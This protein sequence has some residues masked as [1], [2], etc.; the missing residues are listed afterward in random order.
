[1]NYTL[2][3]ATDANDF[4]SIAE[5][6]KE[7]WHN[8]Y[9]DIIGAEQVDYMLDKFQS[10]DA[11][12]KDVQQNGY[13]YLIA[14]KDDS[15]LGYCGIKPEGNR[16]IFLSKVYVNPKFQRNGIAKTMIQYLI[17]EYRRLG[18]THMHLTVNKNNSNAIAAYQKL[19]F[20][21]SGELV[22]DIGNGFVMDDDTMILHF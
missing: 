8:T 18:Y 2:T 6:A 13:R 1:M 14:K 20:C 21:K 16:Q 11:I 15:I 7:V 10:T 9:D 3:E 5:L 17:D 12:Q 19:G 22:T 4:S